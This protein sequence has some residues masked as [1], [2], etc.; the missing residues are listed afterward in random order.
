MY[1]ITSLDVYGVAVCTVSVPRFFSKGERRGSVAAT[2]DNGC[3]AGSCPTTPAFTMDPRWSPHHQTYLRTEEIACLL[4][5]LRYL[6][7]FVCLFVVMFLISAII[8]LHT[9]IRGKYT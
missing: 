3:L 9:P 2:S 8:T 1:W 5:S 7:S 6:D 4:S